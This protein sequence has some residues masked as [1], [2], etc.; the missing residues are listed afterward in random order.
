M[1]D[2]LRVR[3]IWSVARCEFLVLIRSAR[4]WIAL[5][6]GVCSLAA[7]AA[8]LSYVSGPGA[9]WSITAQLFSAKYLTSTLG[10]PLVLVFSVLVVLLGCDYLSRDRSIGIDESI[11]AHPVRNH[12]LILGRALCIFVV[13]QLLFALSVTLL[14]V[15]Q[16]VLQAVGLT[17]G[18]SSWTGGLAY[19]FCDA[20]AVLGFWTAFVVLVGTLLKNRLL[21]AV[22]ALGFV[23]TH[24]VVAQIAPIH[25]SGYLSGV[26]PLTP[27]M[28]SD[29]LASYGDRIPTFLHR[30]AVLLIALGIVAVAVLCLNR[31]D[32]LKKLSIATIGLLLLGFGSS[33]LFGLLKWED[34][35]KEE[36]I[37]WI[38]E[39]RKYA[40][41]PIADLVEIRGHVR[42]VPGESLEL[43]LV[44]VLSAQ[45]DTNLNELVLSLNP[46]LAISSL[47]AGS[48]EHDDYTFEYGL[49]RI[50]LDEPLL[51]DERLEIGISAIGEPNVQFA[52]LEEVVDLRQQPRATGLPILALGHAPSIFDRT[53]VALVP[54]VRW[55][56]IPGSTFR[57]SNVDQ[58]TR[59][60]FAV[61][62]TVTVPR[63]WT[64][65]APD[66][67]STSTSDDLMESYQIAPSIAIPNFMLLASEF[68]TNA[69]QI[70]GIE[71]ELLLHK[72]HR[73]VFSWAADYT[74]GIERL[75]SQWLK[76]AEE[77]G[78]GYPYQRFLFVEIPSTLRA[79]GG[80][81]PLGSALA[82]PGVSTFREWS[83]PAVSVTTLWRRH[84]AS[85]GGMQSEYLPDMLVNNYI[86]PFLDSDSFGSRLQ[87]HLWR[88]FSTHQAHA[89][90]QGAVA[91]DLVVRLLT[92]YVVTNSGPNSRWN[93]RPEFSALSVNREQLVERLRSRT[94]PSFL[95]PIGNDAFSYL[96]LRALEGRSGAWSALARPLGDLTEQNDP[97]FEWRLL[98]VKCFAITTMLIRALG[99]ED[100]GRFL[101]ALRSKFTGSTYTLEDI[102]ELADE[103]SLPVLDYIDAWITEPGLP[104]IIVDNVRV[105]EGTD[106]EG[107]TEYQVSV[108]VHNKERIPG[109]VTIKLLQSWSQ[110][111]YW[112][113]I[114]TN[115]AKSVP[116]AANSRVEVSLTSQS[117][118]E[119]LQIQPFLSHNRFQWDIQLP[120]PILNGS[121][122]EVDSAY[123]VTE[124]NG[125]VYSERVV[126]D[127]LD[128]A[129]EVDSDLVSSRKFRFGLLFGP[130]S[131]LQVDED[132]GLPK[133]NPFSKDPQVW[134]RSEFAGAHGNYRRT[135]A[136]GIG[137]DKDSWARFSA[138][139]EVP[140]LWQLQYHLPVDP[141]LG[142][143][144]ENM[145][146]ANI[147]V[148][149]SVPL[150]S[151]GTYTLRVLQDGVEEQISFDASVGTMGWNDVG[152]FDLTSGSVGVEVSSKSDGTFVYADAVQW[153]RRDSD[154]ESSSR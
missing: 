100:S 61:D 135:S 123:Q 43:D 59:D 143:S 94:A 57:S 40:D 16:R 97:E 66:R 150:S 141:R 1:G 98:N 84:I 151:Q 147:A 119:Y 131:R 56:P 112:T 127:D 13:A 44:L 47:K 58:R 6:I 89:S 139:L 28:P 62:L 8:I 4:T 37:A 60:S 108:E 5:L 71:V 110:P 21:V 111:P 104:G 125:L 148:A 50:A 146:V 96:L 120:R 79:Y 33:V 27:S 75:T 101:A 12:E 114:P 153:L 83:L 18:V 20:A 36:R 46:G 7:A 95:M 86:H 88:N 105:T 32:D 113:L 23:V 154:A 25:H 30:I 121:D 107:E 130:Q 106:Q 14:L 11:R 137:T 74:S 55:L 26:G 109:V 77:K 72:R 80:A 64:I 42:I 136:V 68:A 99:N 92:N 51:P 73:S 122:D 22:V 138:E 124:S 49:L 118:P 39:H 29:L 48:V 149:R 41:E 69:M 142:E 67:Q 144:F 34:I 129:F 133:Y 81:L 90:G 82:S 9:S 117:E 115:I 52:Y 76:S 85:F 65:A 126:V 134:S 152:S 87:S 103:L 140:G 132:A 17:A 35:R 53:Y 128:S 19:I 70:E 78:L 91:L 45:G 31:R 10:G 2:E 63:G 145:Y 38:Q 93:Y 15:V 116:V 24:Y 54:A 3:R 102:K